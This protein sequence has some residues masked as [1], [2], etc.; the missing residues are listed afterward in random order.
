M[1]PAMDEA[2]LWSK[3]RKIEAL[4][5]GTNSDGEREAARLAA[6]RIR[7]RLAAQR[8]EWRDIV[9][10]YSLADPWKRK[11]FLALCRR[12]GLTPYREKGQRSST[13]QV[14]APRKFHQKTLWP[15]YLALA[16]ELEKHLA[17]LTDRVIRE[18]I[19]TD[20]SEAAEGEPKGLP[21]PEPES[22]P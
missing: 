11:L 6:E 14:L 12:Y 7:A 20:V 9:M 1:A 19:H 13:V 16:E 22:E 18:A 17:D 10:V 3:L 8:T 2:T 21:E 15:E 4:H 5:A